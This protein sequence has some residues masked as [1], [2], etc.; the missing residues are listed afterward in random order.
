MLLP[1]KSDF[2][3]N[4][5]CVAVEMILFKSLVLLTFPNPTIEDDMPDTLPVIVIEEPFILV[6]VAD[7]PIV[8]PELD[9][10]FV[11]KLTAFVADC[12]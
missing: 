10:K 8:K 3:F 2:K 4:A 9:V 12:A 6:G 11:A 1:D 7:E 5:V